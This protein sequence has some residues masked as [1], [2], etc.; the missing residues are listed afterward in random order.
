MA[1]NGYEGLGWIQRLLQELP[2]LKLSLRPWALCFGCAV[3][4]LSL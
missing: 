2:Q 1:D 4:R 3:Y